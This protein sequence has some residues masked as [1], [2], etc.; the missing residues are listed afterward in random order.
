MAL[1]PVV[2]LVELVVVLEQSW[3]LLVLVVLLQSLVDTLQ[4]RL[5]PFGTIEEK[6]RMRGRSPW[7][8]SKEVFQYKQ[9]TQM[10]VVV[11][12]EAQGVLDV[13]QSWPVEGLVEVN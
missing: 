9:R 3:V 2:P 11:S 6:V 13:F 8:G 1:L 5:T 10:R 4:L 7:M 12:A